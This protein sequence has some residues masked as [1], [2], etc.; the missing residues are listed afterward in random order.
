MSFG[1]SEM[2]SRI[3]QA[4]HH[5]QGFPGDASERTCLPMQEM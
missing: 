1:V 2:K 4:Y 3:P 5:L